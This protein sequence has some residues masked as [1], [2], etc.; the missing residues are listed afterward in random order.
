MVWHFNGFQLQGNNECIPQPAV[1]LPMLP[2][3]SPLVPF[4]RHPMGQVAFAV[5]TQYQHSID[6]NGL[7]F[8]E[9]AFSTLVHRS[10]QRTYY[11]CHPVFLR[12]A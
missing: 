1:C 6:K 5:T 7:A 9:Y 8:P 12:F 11:G 10:A 3:V 4:E 2:F